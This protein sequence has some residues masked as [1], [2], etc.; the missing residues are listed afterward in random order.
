M[1]VGGRD[2]LLHAIDA[3]TGKAIWTFATRARI[4]SSPAVGG[5]RVYVGSGDGRLYVL[6][7][8]DGTLQWDFEAGAPISASTARSSS[9]R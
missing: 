6:D 4:D 3:G 8:Q 5:D 1:F 7:A 9:K 2:R